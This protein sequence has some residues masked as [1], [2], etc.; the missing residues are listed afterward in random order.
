MAKHWLNSTEPSPPLKQPLPA[1]E[2]DWAGGVEH[3][4]TSFE[5]N[6]RFYVRLEKMLEIYN[7]FL[8]FHL[9]F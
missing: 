5:F 3:V 9:K 1:L 4:R 8:Y 2:L 7:L 6:F